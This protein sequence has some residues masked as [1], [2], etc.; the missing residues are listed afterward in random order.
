MIR[1][2]SSKFYLNPTKVRDD[3]KT[4]IYLRITV[5]RKKA[6]IA[7]GKTIHSK[8]WNEAKQR[9]KKDLLLNEYLNSIEVRLSEI[10]RTLDKEETSF[11]AKALKDILTGKERQ[12]SYLLEYFQSHI[13]F[14]TK[15][16]ELK[17]ETPSRYADT[18]EHLRNF[19]KTERKVNDILLNRIDT[20]FIKEFDLYLLNYKIP[21]KNKTLERNTVNKHLVRFKTIVLKAVSEGILNENSFKSIKIKYNPVK[22]EFLTHEEIERIT[23][24]DL[25]LNPTLDK[26]RDIFLWSIYTG[27]RFADA[28]KISLNEI[29]KDKDN[30]YFLTAK[31]NKTGELVSIPLFTPAER[32]LKKYENEERKVTGRIL[33]QISNQKANVYLKHIATI[34][35]IEKDLSTHVARHTCATTVLLSN[36]APIEVVSKWLGHNNIRTT[37]IYAKITDNYLKEVA[38]KV[39]SKI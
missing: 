33:P 39:E 20:R 38:K 3:G 32:I 8:D 6:E 27:L 36:E 9:A 29:R 21:K 12:E 19:L 7:V 18:L 22:R 25:K 24:L 34:A 35:G 28:Q 11:D 4:P 5:N 2:L 17:K 37:Q 15:N 26:V 30:K 10:A 23:N 13:D 14:L 16:P 1:S 31:Q